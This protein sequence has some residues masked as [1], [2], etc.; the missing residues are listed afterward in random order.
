[1]NVAWLPNRSLPSGERPTSW[2][3]PLP[4]CRV[5]PTSWPHPPP[6]PVESVQQGLLRRPAKAILLAAGM[7]VAALGVVAAGSAL[8]GSN[9]ER[10]AAPS[11]PFSNAPAVGPASPS[12]YGNCSSWL[13][14]TWRGSHNLR[15]PPPP[16]GWNNAPPLPSL[17]SQ[18]GGQ[19][20][21]TERDRCTVRVAGHEGSREADCKLA[22]GKWKV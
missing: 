3:R 5:H 6:L 13:C 15:G 2:S 17:L 4:L 8:L 21:G 19:L 18:A 14:T 12:R 22:G 11:S 10:A 16:L 1:M 20:G 7:A 9:R